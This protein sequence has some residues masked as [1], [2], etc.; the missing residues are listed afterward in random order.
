MLKYL[1]IA[2]SVFLLFNLQHTVAQKK[3]IPQTYEDAIKA[4]KPII[5]KD[6]NGLINWSY[7]YVEATGQGIIDTVRFKNKAQAR[8]MALRGAIVIA[9]RN[10]LEIV[11]GVNIVGETTVEDMITTSDKVQTKVEGVI[12]GA[13]QVGKPRYE[14]GMVEVTMRVPLYAQNSV[15]QAVLEPAKTIIDSMKTNSNARMEDATT[16]SAT[17]PT[18]PAIQEKLKNVV[19]NLDGQKINPSLFPVIVDDKGNLVFDFTKVYDPKKGQFPKYLQLGKDVL[20]ESRF[21]KGVEIIDLIQNS[22]GKLMLKG[23]EKKKNFWGKLINTLGKVAKI[24][25]AF[26]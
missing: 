21:R 6:S 26:I 23:D 25:L 11:K 13:V 5:E 4:A 24:A 20:N 17:P 16:N 7:Q 15:A 8:A 1:S 10:L 3:Q 18:D 19:F 22:D 14:D 2:T 9:Q 12:K